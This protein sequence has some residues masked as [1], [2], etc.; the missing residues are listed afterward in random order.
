MKR[1]LCIVL[2]GCFGLAG[3]SAMSMETV[4][5][6]EGEFFSIAMENDVDNLGEEE[7]FQGCYN[8]G[9]T[10]SLR[11]FRLFTDIKNPAKSESGEIY[12]GDTITVYPNKKIKKTIDQYGRVQIYYWVVVEEGMGYGAGY[13]L[14]NHIVKIDPYLDEGGVMEPYEAVYDNEYSLSI[15]SHPVDA[16]EFITGK[17]NEGDIV[18]VYPEKSVKYSDLSDS[19]KHEEYVLFWIKTS[20]GE[21][22]YIRKKYL[23]EPKTKTEMPKSQE[24]QALTD[25]DEYIYDQ[26]MDVF[27]AVKATEETVKGMTEEQKQSATGIDLATL[28][29]ET[30]TAR[31]AAKSV[32]GNE[33]IID[34]TSVSD[35][36][37]VAAQAS[38][39]VESALV[40]GGVTPE[41]VL[42]KTVTLTSDSL[43][44]LSI[45]IEPDILT[46]GV[47]EASDGYIAGTRF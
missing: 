19:Y 34:K 40:N 23:T 47:D 9:T 22:G 35:L 6:D 27:S 39:A 29:A 13:T 36:Q 14:K 43:D 42:S 8:Y 41:R 21:E 10:L 15:Y 33:I 2:L 12:C 28:S 44:E 37:A 30:A 31:A 11:P 24:S 7:T 16:K 1:L 4:Y 25:S 38:T 26:V 3:F 17:L 46:S 32:S 18:T 20:N 45:R 5:A